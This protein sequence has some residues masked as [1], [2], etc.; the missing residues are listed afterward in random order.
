MRLSQRSAAPEVMDSDAVDAA[1]YARCLA[2]LGRLNRLTLT[3]RPTLR[4]LDRASRDLPRTTPIAILDVA[5]GGGDLLRTIRHWA[6]RSGRTVSLQGIDLNPRSAVVARAATTPAMAITYVTG[7]VFAYDPQ[8]APDF[9][10]SSQFMHHLSD[11]EAVR[12]LRWLD[13]HAAR[14]WYVADLRRHAMPYYGFRFLAT[15]ARWHPIVRSD[16]TI[17]I[18]RGF[19]P[20]ELRRLVA[21]AG[22]PAEVAGHVPFRV[23]IGRI[24]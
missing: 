24:G 21:A 9:I 12:F 1:T 17:S 22:V 10:V 2:D 5:C 19:R 6:D 7:D 18:A 23:G 16:G 20:A 3:H 4:W 13:A 8:P 14:G 15:A 11:D